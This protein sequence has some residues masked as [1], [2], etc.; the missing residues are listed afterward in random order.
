MKW[1]WGTG[2][3]V[4]MAVFMVGILSLVYRAFHNDT[5]LV[6]P[7]YYEKE[8]HYQKTIDAIERAK[9]LG[10]QSHIDK[11]Q[12]QMVISFS[13]RSALQ[14][15]K[16]VIH[17]YRPDNQRL[18][19]RFDMAPSILDGQL[20]IPLNGLKRGAYTVKLTWEK[21]GASYYWEKQVWL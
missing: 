1:N 5:D 3:A 20:V 14:G 11:P 15:A 4:F 8:V 17:L 7:E 19:K 6:S 21:Q 2:I 12:S 16:G 10:M 13:N 9:N 18:D